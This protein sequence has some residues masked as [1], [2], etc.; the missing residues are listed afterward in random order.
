MLTEELRGLAN[1]IARGKIFDSGSPETL[2][3]AALEIE[4]LE[5]DVLILGRKWQEAYDEAERLRKIAYAADSFLSELGD[6][7]T[8]FVVRFILQDKLDEWKKREKK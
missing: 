8:E 5:A 7:G 6:T 3:R 1:D 4:R 2:L